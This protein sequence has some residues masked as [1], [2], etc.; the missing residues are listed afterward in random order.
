MLTTS[1][2]CATPNHY[3]VFNVSHHH[4]HHHPAAM[5]LGH[6]L[7]RFGLTHPEVSSL[8]SPGSLCLLFCDFL[9]SSVICYKASPVLSNKYSEHSYTSMIIT[10]YLLWDTANF[11]TGKPFFNFSLLHLH[12]Y[13]IF[14]VVL[15]VVAVGCIVK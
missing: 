9:L 4:H 15:R 3:C 2:I 12:S 14:L 13:Q 10:L 8:V 1:S 6:L 7:I 5:E 11:D